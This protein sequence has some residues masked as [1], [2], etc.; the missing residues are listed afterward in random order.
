MSEPRLTQAHIVVRGL[1]Q[2]VYFRGSLK[3]EA[4]ARHVTGWVRNRADG[5]VEAVLQGTHD[6]VTAVLAWARHGP[7]IGRAHV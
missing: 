3:Q 2:G 4:D 5:S 7:Q 6:A 1:V